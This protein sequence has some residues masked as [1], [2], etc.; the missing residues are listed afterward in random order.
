MEAKRKMISECH[1]CKHKRSV[2]GNAHIQCVM[3]DMNMTGYEHGIKNGWFYYPFLFDPTW[4][5]KMCINYEPKEEV[6]T[7]ISQSVS[8]AGK[9]E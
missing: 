2:P 8:D 9:S 3:P 1:H 6:S 7:V 5:T 4:K